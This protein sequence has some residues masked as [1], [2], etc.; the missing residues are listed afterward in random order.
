MKKNI[1][2]FLL[3]VLILLSAFAFRKDSSNETYVRNYSERLIRFQK[4][5]QLLTRSISSGQLDEKQKQA[6]TEKIHTLRNEVKGMDFWLRYLEP[7]AYKKI[8]G[9]L[10]VEWETEVFEKFEKPYRREGAGLTLTEIYLGDNLVNGDSIKYLISAAEMAAHHYVKDSLQQIL[11]S[12]DHF[13]FCNRLFLL[14]LSAIYTTGFE[15][16]DPERIIPE[17]RLMLNEVNIIYAN[18]ESSFPEIKLGADY[19][20][21]YENARQFVNN[22]PENATEFDH[23]TFIRDFINP[24]FQLN[25]E[26]IR[27]HELKSISPIDYSLNPKSTSIFNKDLYFA[28]NTR[29]I[30]SRIRDPK[31]QEQIYRLGEKLFYDPLLSGNNQRSCASCHKAENYFADTSVSSNLQFDGISQLQ[32][33]TPSLMTAPYQHLLMHDGK[34][35]TLQEQSNAVISN[36]LEMHCQEKDLIKKLL[37]CEDYKKTFAELLKHTPQEEAVNIR[38]VSSALTTYYSSFSVYSSDFDQQI[39]NEK[40][41]NQAVAAGFNLFMSKAQCATCHFPPHFNGVKPPYTGSEFE[42]IGVP[43]SLNFT[44]VNPDVGRHFINPAYE[45]EHAFRTA[46]LKN[47]A[48]TAPYMHNGLF[49]TLKEVVDFYD[50]GGGAGRGLK[51]DN[52][53]LSSDSLRLTPKEKRDLIV[54]MESLTEKIPKIRVPESLPISKNKT[55]N[56]RK[57]GGL[58]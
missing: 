22:Q 51:L 48:M 3:L 7:L 40:E 34:H 25:Q 36:S 38:H 47:I 11:L 37:T 9:P 39:K 12:P 30:Y 42:V 4:N 21:I 32:R 18:F 33:N 43:S 19:H 29:G 17:L 57:P 35:T 44:A 50:A 24:L 54:F 58:Y 8:N 13:F 27:K 20:T 45:T 5:C 31:I 6:L 49:K 10:P 14:N 52:Q 41:K 46:G 26:I 28:Q 2:V 53:T 56:T 1:L 15:C 55:F 16:P 23:F